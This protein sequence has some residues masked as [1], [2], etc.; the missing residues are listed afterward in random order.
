METGQQSMQNVE[1]DVPNIQNICLDTTCILFHCISSM[2][3]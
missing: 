2:D 1:K 3:S